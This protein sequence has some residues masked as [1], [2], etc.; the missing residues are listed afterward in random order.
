M[1]MNLSCCPFCGSVPSVNAY[2]R[3]IVIGCDE[4]KYTRGF[5]GLLQKTASAVPI[6]QYMNAAGEVEKVA[7]DKVHEWYHADAHKKAEEAWNKRYSES[8]A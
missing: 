6:D 3:L 7:P 4:C 5:P 2:D 8:A 1:S